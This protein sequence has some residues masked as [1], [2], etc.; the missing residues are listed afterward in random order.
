MDKLLEQELDIRILED[1]SNEGINSL[2]NEFEGRIDPKEIDR[3]AEVV[4]SIDA[5]GYEML[6]RELK[7][8]H[9]VHFGSEKLAVTNNRLKI[10]L[11][12]VVLVALFTA[13]FFFFQSSRTSSLDATELYAEYHEPYEYNSVTRSGTQKSLF[14]LGRLYQEKMYGEFIIQYENYHKQKDD[15]TSEFILAIGVA[16][17]ESG[18][19]YKGV[20]QYDRIIDN[21][22][23]SFL[24]IA[25]WYKSLALLKADE[26]TDCIKILEELISRDSE[27]RKQAEA[28]LK[29]VRKIAI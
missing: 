14:E 25:L 9:K 22:D 18:E 19:P 28:L 23:F 15:L 29:D 1:A 13:L 3:H 27:F 20:Y 2:K 10:A 17:T 11:A 7:D 16:Y 8:I 21:Q 26:K 5:F 4:K 6:R 24:D 12:L